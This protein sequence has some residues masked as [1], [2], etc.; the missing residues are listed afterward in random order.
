MSD[1]EV[2]VPLATALRDATDVL[3]RA[4]V[5]SPRWDAEQLAAHVTGVP[6]SQLARFSDLDADAAGRFQA[7]VARRAAR[8]P[9]QHLTGVVGF[10]YLDL[11]VGPGVFI[12]RP[13]TEVVVGY[14]IDA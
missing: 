2:A 8:V 1:T 13:E 6:K 10:R 12:P 3:A 5:E 4:G 11:D 9:L 7:L 14:A